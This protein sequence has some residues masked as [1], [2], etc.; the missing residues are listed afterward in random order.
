M[1]LSVFI[2]LQ[3]K[4]SRIMYMVHFDDLNADLDYDDQTETLFA[5][6]AY[7]LDSRGNRIAS[8]DV[9]D[10][11]RKGDILNYESRIRRMSPFPP[12]R[13]Y[14]VQRKRRRLDSRLGRR[15]HHVQLPHFRLAVRRD[16]LPDQQL[17]G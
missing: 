8:S 17:L 5:S 12:P 15:I 11:G 9:I 1:P 6:F 10:G 13:G 4:A 16:L 3:G 14:Q 7:T 2:L